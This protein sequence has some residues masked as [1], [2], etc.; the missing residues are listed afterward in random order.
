M[1]TSLQELRDYLQAKAQTIAE[2][3][4]KALAAIEQGKDEPAYRAFMLEKAQLL[5]NLEEDARPLLDKLRGAPEFGRIYATIQGFSENARTA[6]G[7]G[8]VFFMSALLYP[9]EHK[10]GTP[11]NLELFVQKM[12]R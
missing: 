7:I 11:N 4:A 8:S 12:I 9:D 6:L 2:L 1:P 10:K 3:E 5:A